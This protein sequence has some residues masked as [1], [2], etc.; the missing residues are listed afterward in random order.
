MMRTLVFLLLLAGAGWAQPAAMILRLDGHA[1][2]TVD[3]LTSPARS[4]LKLPDGATVK[5]Q[6]GRVTFFYF[7]DRHQEVATGPAVINV[8][9]KG[10][11]GQGLQ[12]QDAS[13]SVSSMPAGNVGRMGGMAVRGSTRPRLVMAGPAGVLPKVQW[14]LPS[15]PPP[16]PYQ[17]TLNTAAG[18]ELWTKEVSG[19]SADYDGPPLTEGTAYEWELKAG[20]PIYRRFMV[21]SDESRKAL[22]NLR[23]E[24]EK[25][26]KDDA[27][28]YLLLMTLSD[29]YGCLEQAISAGR[30]A[31]K[32]RPKDG[33]IQAALAE[34]YEQAGL[35]KE[36]NDS[37][38]KARALGVKD[39]Y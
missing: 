26:P 21:L 2:V 36:M 23:L 5:V 25:A 10:G 31:A 28:P 13:G 37:I 20:E 3:N 15:P 39:L 4:L 24:A 19:T 16:A 33:G 17:L 9:A 11:E 35:Y 22:E 38:D 29:N 14:V 30:A 1:Q 34:L 32:R 8:T 7:S 6:D 27:G 18:K 12:R